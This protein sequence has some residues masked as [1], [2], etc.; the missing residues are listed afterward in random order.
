MT[1]SPHIFLRAIPLPVCLSDDNPKPPS[2]QA[3]PVPRSRLAVFLLPSRDVQTSH[4]SRPRS[5]VKGPLFSFYFLHSRRL[6]RPY[7]LKYL[8]LAFPVDPTATSPAIA[9]PPRH[10]HTHTLSLSLSLSLS[11]P[12]SSLFCPRACAPSGKRV[13][14]IDPGATN[15]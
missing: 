13:L 6:R 14:R 11:S 5:L 4:K 1:P 15:L 10:T 3:S 2:H 12:S 9:S 8:V 7:K